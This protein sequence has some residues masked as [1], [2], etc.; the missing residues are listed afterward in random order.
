MA[1][2]RSEHRSTLFQNPCSLPPCHT[3]PNTGPPWSSTLSFVQ[4]HWQWST[5]IKIRHDMQGDRSQPEDDIITEQLD[6]HSGWPTS[7]VPQHRWN[8]AQGC[9]RWVSMGKN[10]CLPYWCCLMPSSLG[11]SKENIPT[12]YPNVVVP[13]GGWFCSPTPNRGHLAKSGVI[14]GCHTGERMLLASSA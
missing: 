7:G 10:E 8:Q 1:E 13:N 11:I 5:D 12:D 14:F 4:F 2:N 9:S 6:L 3:K